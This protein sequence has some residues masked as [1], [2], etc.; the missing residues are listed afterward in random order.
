MRQNEGDEAGSGL[1]LGS[2]G[3]RK[4]GSLSAGPAGIHGRGSGSTSGT[5]L[6]ILI[7]RSEQMTATFISFAGR[8]LHLMDFGI[9]NRS[10][11]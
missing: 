4:A 7:S 9:W 11:N 6:P 8:Q 5:D 1:L 2:N 3:G 10:G